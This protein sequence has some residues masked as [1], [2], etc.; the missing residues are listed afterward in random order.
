VEIDEVV[1]VKGALSDLVKSPVDVCCAPVNSES[2]SHEYT[3][4]P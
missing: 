4:P 1:E 2:M 3:G